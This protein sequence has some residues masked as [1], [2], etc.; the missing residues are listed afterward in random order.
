[1]IIA[2]DIVKWHLSSR[3]RDNSFQLA[4]GGRFESSTCTGVARVN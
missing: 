4:A 2:E 1:M 3:L